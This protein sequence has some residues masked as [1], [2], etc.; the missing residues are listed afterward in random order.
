VPQPRSLLDRK[1][2]LIFTTTFVVWNP[3]ER[4]GSARAGFYTQSWDALPCTV[5]R[6]FA[7]NETPKRCKLQRFAGILRRISGYAL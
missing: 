2:I 4:M 1:Y 6:L 3:S 5:A 7:C